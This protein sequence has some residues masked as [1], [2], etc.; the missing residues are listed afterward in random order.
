MAHEVSD[1][2]DSIK[3]SITDAQY[4]EGMEMCQALFQKKESEKKLYQMTYLRPYTFLDHHCD[5]DDCDDMKYLIS[6]R[7]TTGLARLTDDHVEKIRSTGCFFGTTEEMKSFIDIDVLTS[8]PH[9]AED[10][11]SEIHWFEFPVL[12]LELIS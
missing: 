6:F 5:E 7:K 11:G 9:D 12:N 8:F 1:F 10:L 2:I 4:K 3:E